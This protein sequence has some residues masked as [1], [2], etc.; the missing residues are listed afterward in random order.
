M[1]PDCCTFEGWEVVWLQGQHSRVP[2]HS[3]MELPSY[4]VDVTQSE[5]EHYQSMYMYIDYAISL[6][7]RGNTL[8]Q[9]P[10]KEKYAMC[11]Y[12]IMYVKQY[13]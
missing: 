13:V 11:I 9:D 2:G 1:I 7:G 12:L 10:T 4:L 3:L 6:T 5:R 8:I